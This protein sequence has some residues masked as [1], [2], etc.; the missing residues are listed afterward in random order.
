MVIADGFTWFNRDKK[1]VGS[2]DAL[3]DGNTCDWCCCH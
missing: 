3:N 2:S 1:S